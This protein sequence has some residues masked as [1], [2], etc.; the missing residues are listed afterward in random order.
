[1]C[2]VAPS[3][4]SETALPTEKNSASVARTRGPGASWYTSASGGPPIEVVV[5]VTPATTPAPASV[6]GFATMR[7]LLKLRPTAISTITPTAMPSSRGASPASSHTANNVPH[8]RPAIAI[9]AP[10]TST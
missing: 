3:E 9:P 2:P 8:T 1:M 4:L 5:A 10:R 6:A 7:R